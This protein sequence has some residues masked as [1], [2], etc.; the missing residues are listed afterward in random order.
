M[1][2]KAKS[3]SDVEVEEKK[4]PKP[5]KIFILSY[6]FWD[7]GEAT[8]SRVEKVPQERGAPKNLPYFDEDVIDYT[9]SL[10]SRL[11]KDKFELFS[12]LMKGLA[13]TEEEVRNFYSI[14]KESS[15]DVAPEVSSCSVKPPKKS[16]VDD[17]DFEKETNG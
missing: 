11:G 6:E 13:I 4:P 2:R 8:C 14:E 16:K 1:G 3:P 10:K 9:T 17:F 12:V 15:D 7:D 5:K